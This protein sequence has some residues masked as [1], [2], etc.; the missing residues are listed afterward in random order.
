M[1]RL[2]Q[3]G[4]AWWLSQQSIENY[5]KTDTLM[6]SEQTNKDESKNL[7]IGSNCVYAKGH[8]QIVGSAF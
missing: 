1:C 5:P 4:G 7:P 6:A 2:V 3:G 8:H